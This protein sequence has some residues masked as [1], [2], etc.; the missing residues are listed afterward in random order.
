MPQRDAILRLLRRRQDEMSA[1]LE[2]LVAIPTE[3]P[4][5]KNYRACVDL[6]EKQ[7][8]QAGLTCE[9]IAYEH[10]LNGSDQA[11]C[12]VATYGSGPRALYLHGHYMW[13]RRN[14]RSGFVPPAKS[15]LCLCAAIAI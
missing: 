8:R 2:D 1:M 3:N 10:S 7:L 4:P 6:L 9:R 13:F 14:Q 11:E 15:S 5:G 12:V